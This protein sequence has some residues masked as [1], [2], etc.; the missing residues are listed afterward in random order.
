MTPGD[1]IRFARA[2]IAL[3]ARQTVFRWRRG[4]GRCPCQAPSDSGRAW[5]TVCEEASGW[6]RPES[7][8]RVCPNFRRGPQGWRCAVDTRDVR[9]HWGRAAGYL[10]AV[11]LALYAVGATVGYV[12]LRRIGYVGVG[13][14]DVAWPGHWSRIAAAQR[15][16]FLTQ[17]RA[18][19]G[20]LD[21]RAMRVSLA[22]AATAGR[23]HF[24]LR[25]ALAQIHS[26]LSS[27]TVVTDAFE[28]LRRDFPERWPEA[29]IAYH[30][31]LLAHHQVGRLGDLALGELA[32]P[33]RGAEGADG[34]WL[35][36]AFVALRG[37]ESAPA[38]LQRNAAAM[39]KIGTERRE[40][41]AE[42][43]AARAGD[44]AAAAAL[45][46]RIRSSMD[47]ALVL[48][49]ADLVVD[50]LP[51]TE[52]LDVAAAVGS[53]LGA[54]ERERL[55]L[56]VCV[57]AGA[58]RRALAAFD[59]MLRAAARPLQRERLLAVLVEFPDPERMRRLWPA[60]AN[61][62][63]PFSA[64]EVGGLWVAAAVNGDAEIGA[65]AAQRLQAAHG[66]EIGRE[67]PRGDTARGASVWARILPLGRE[68]GWVLALRH[69]SG[70]RAEP[71][72]RP[73]GRH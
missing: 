17:A 61:A 66:V 9:P 27:G 52:A 40:A 11:L 10:G 55:V 16:H 7:F 34:A 21:D 67:F 5:E 51:E 24:E 12:G 50:T 48:A 58:A 30:D 71:T 15:E 73:P 54:F 38:L 42:A 41:L 32:R 63:S 29:A 13:W 44:R 37:A 20:Q 3:N 4:R 23:A 39:A 69:G 14:T 1:S 56:R 19:L 46:A 22:S 70:A 72:A 49:A 53:R 59:T 28:E 8:R 33:T 25:L 2:L 26:Y 62:T 36:A 60:A 6:D 68:I 45:G 18:A 64:R 43:A 35:R 47:L 57:R 31:M 65:L